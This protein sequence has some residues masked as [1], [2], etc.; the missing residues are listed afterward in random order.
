MNILVLTI[1]LLFSF[2]GLFLVF[3]GLPGNFFI[4]LLS[5][6]LA[7]YY[8]FE[9]IKLNIL[10]ILLVLALAGELL[11]FVLG[12]IGSKRKKSSNQAIVGSIICSIIGAI[13]FAPLFFGF[14]AVVGAFAGAFFG[15]FIVEYI[16]NKNISVAY[17]SGLGA[18]LGRLGGTLVKS[19][20]GVIM[21]TITLLQVF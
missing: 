13:V 12:I 15:A 21:I 8:K 16:K 19:V 1:Y 11:E 10:I 2:A 20:I 9:I 6:L 7:W 5:T 14:G 3:I 17:Q 18:F 4:L